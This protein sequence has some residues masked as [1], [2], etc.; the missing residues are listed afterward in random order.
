MKLHHTG[1]LVKNIEKSIQTFKTLGYVEKLY[2]DQ[3][4]VMFDSYR[5]CDISF[6]ELPN[7]NHV[8]ELVAPLNEESPIWGLMSKYKN[9]PYHLCFE[10]ENIDKDIKDLKENG[11][12]VFQNPAVAPAIDNHNVVFLLHRYAGIIELIDMQK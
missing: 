8:I 7:T 9:T 3:S 2:S 4:I 10:S 1:Y 5:K 11:W 12:V 6:M